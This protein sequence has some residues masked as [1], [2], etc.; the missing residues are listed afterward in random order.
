MVS[1]PPRTQVRRGRQDGGGATV[2]PP[3]TGDCARIHERRFPPSRG[4]ARAPSSGA[5]GPVS[6]VSC[7]RSWRRAWGREGGCQAERLLVSERPLAP[8]YPSAHACM[9]EQSPRGRTQVRFCPPTNLP[10]L[11][12]EEEEKGA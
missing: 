8:S 1:T 5:L 9:S 6:E 4:A 3:L 11:R 12:G 2:S 10:P 7:A